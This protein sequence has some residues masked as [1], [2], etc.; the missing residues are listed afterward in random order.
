MHGES[1]P[2][3]PQKSLARLKFCECCACEAKQVAQQYGAQDQKRHDDDDG[4]D[5][6]NSREPGKPDG[7]QVFAKTQNPVA[8][9]FRY[10][11]Y[12]RP[13]GSFSAVGSERDASREKSRSPAPLLR[14]GSRSAV[15]DQGRCGRTDER[16]DCVPYGVQIRNFVGKKFDDVERDGNAKNDRMRDH[17]ESRRQMNDTE[18]LQES[19][20]RDSGVEVEAGG[21]TGAQGQA[22]GLQRIHKLR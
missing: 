9:W 2:C 21:K 18:S 20:S 14:S 6:M 5:G 12:G 13:R 1:K 11:V 8:D 16:M 4:R 7:Q 17:L 19:K 10:G 3:I 22:E 15:C